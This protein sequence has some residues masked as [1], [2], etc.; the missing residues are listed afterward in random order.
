MGVGVRLLSGVLA[1]I[2]DDGRD[3][4]EHAVFDVLAGH[5]KGERGIEGG[6]RK[7]MLDDYG[8]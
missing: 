5:F 6:M 7:S 8:G 2:V 1:E 4:G 3:L